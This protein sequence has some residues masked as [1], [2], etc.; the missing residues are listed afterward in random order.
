[1]IARLKALTAAVDRNRMTG[2]SVTAATHSRLGPRR[3]VAVTYAQL[4]GNAPVA[5]TDPVQTTQSA[6]HTWIGANSRSSC[7]QAREG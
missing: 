4:R 5:L 2:S 1:M 7:I 3:I 6:R